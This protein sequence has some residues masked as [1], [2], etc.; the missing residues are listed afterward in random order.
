M[1]IKGFLMAESI[2]ALAIALFAVSCLYLTVSE[3]K[4]NERQMEL[5]VDRAYAQ[6]VLR[7]SGCQQ[8]MVH[9]KIYEKD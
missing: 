4:K 8:I 9:D 7:K 6:H 2:I 1:K 5:K 3:N